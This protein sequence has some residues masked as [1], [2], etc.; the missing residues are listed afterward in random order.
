[1]YSPKIV[2]KNGAEVVNED[3]N[4]GKNKRSLLDESVFIANGSQPLHIDIVIW[5]Y[6]IVIQ[7]A[8][9]LISYHM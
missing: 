6:K 1:M 9:Y 4:Q 2:P 3:H 5:L 8:F 7:A